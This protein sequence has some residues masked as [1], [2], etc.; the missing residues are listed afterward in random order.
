MTCLGHNH[1]WNCDC[2]FGETGSGDIRSAAERAELF[3]S[4]EVA[5]PDR[6]C[7]KCGA[8]TY[9]R[10]GGRGGILFDRVGVGR[11]LRHACNDQRLRY[12]P[13]NLAGRPK[14]RNRRTRLDQRGFL[15]IAIEGVEALDEGNILRCRWLSEPPAFSLRSDALLGL[16]PATPLSLRW[17]G[18]EVA[19][20]SY[21][22]G[23]EI[24][25][26]KVVWLG[27]D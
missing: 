17:R 4:E 11:W 24:C 8:P 10:A 1:R 20:L 23:G 12:A 18:G 13:F 19:T 6:T 26:A 9:F 15:P 21:V 16:E 14:L 5:E 3:K 22:Q 7:R 25:E 2:G 27:R